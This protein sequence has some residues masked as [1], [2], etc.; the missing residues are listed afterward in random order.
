MH[1]YFVHKFRICLSDSMSST[2]PYIDE[3]QSGNS[4]ISCCRTISVY[5][6]SQIGK[7]NIRQRQ[8][9]FSHARAVALTRNSVYIRA[10]KHA[11]CERILEDQARPIFNLGYFLAVCVN[12][13]S[14]D[15]QNVRR[16]SVH[17]LLF[18]ETCKFFL[19]Q[20]QL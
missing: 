1:S 17:L 13:S 8:T 4:T 7:K 15:T 10:I 16:I 20:S 14:V 18:N 5:K 11:K 12:V 6:F 9:S 19:A 2:T 3:C